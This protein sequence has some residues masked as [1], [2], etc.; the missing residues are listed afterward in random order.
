MD[1]TFSIKLDLQQSRMQLYTQFNLWI[2]EISPEDAGYYGCG[3]PIYE[4]THENNWRTEK[5]SLRFIYKLEIPGRL[6]RTGR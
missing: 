2:S 5:S 3:L 6:L 1:A 4:R